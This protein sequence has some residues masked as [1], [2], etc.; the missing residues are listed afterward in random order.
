[1]S[2]LNQVELWFSKIERDVLARGVFTSVA[3]LARK[4]RRYVRHY[5]KR[6]KPI[7]WT[8]C[9]AVHRISSTSVSTVH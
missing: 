4:I 9:N 7:R 5:N 6:A 3:D 8:Y 1:M 2:W